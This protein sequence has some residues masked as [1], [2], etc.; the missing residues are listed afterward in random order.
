M[1]DENEPPRTPITEPELDTRL[2]RFAAMIEAADSPEKVIEWLDDE[3]GDVLDGLWTACG[4]RLSENEWDA[5]FAIL[6]RIYAVLVPEE[7]ERL[8]IDEERL[9]AGFVA[10]EKTSGAAF[11]ASDISRSRQPVILED[12][13]VVLAD[14]VQNEDVLKGASKHIAMALLAAV[15][16][17]LDITMWESQQE[18]EEDSG[19]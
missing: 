4:E 13:L 15:V 3:A 9:V 18:E 2:D 14:I 17:E 5:M 6:P 16:D 11:S 1:S 12:A 19:S 7:F 10:W 8:E